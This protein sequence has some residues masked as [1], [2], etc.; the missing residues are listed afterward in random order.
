MTANEDIYDHDFHAWA[1][2]QAR[3]L[4]C[5]QIANA[6][7]EHIAEEIETLGASERRE[8]ESRLKVLLLH[9]LKWQHQPD[10]RSSGWIGTIDEQRDQIDT[11]LRESP[12]LRRLVG[13]YV[14]FAYPK[15]RRS[16]GRETGLA[17]K[18]F[19]E[20][21]PYSEQ[22]ILDPDFWPE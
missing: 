4:R 12:S 21:S 18:V 17:Q 6:D 15:A 22:G 9:L 11:L 20:H 16:A 10:A 8:L 19:P 14:G 5:G 13:E 3:L 1:E 7:V 2:K